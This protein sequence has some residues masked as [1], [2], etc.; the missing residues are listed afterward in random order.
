MV[1]VVAF[2]GL[3]CV[4][5]S[6]AGQS[7][8][9]KGRAERLLGFLVYDMRSD[10]EAVGRLDLAQKVKDR[11]DEYHRRVGSEAALPAFITEVQPRQ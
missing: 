6:T 10:L 5:K 1:L 4:V 11:V 2:A 3:T 8:P 7:D 9:R